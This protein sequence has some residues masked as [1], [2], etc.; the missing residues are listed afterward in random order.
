MQYRS[1]NGW[2]DDLR[3]YVLYNSISVI[4]GRCMGN[5]KRPYVMGHRL[6]SERSPSQAGLEQNEA[7]TICSLEILP[8]AWFGGDKNLYAIHLVRR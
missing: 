1:M 3:F 2:M 6:R 5:N 4:L 8:G 7:A